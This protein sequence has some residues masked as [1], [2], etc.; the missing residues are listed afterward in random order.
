VNDYGKV[1]AMQEYFSDR[2]DDSDK[3]NPFLEPRPPASTAKLFTYLAAL[4]KGY[5]PFSKEYS[6]ESFKWPGDKKEL[7][8][9]QHRD[10]S[11]KINMFQA[12]AESQNIVT[13]R[14]AN[15]IGE[16]EVTRIAKSITGLSETL[17]ENKQRN[18]EMKTGEFPSIIGKGA[19]MIIGQGDTRITLI[20][21]LKAYATV[22]NNGIQVEPRFIQNI[23]N[24]NT[25]K[26]QLTKA[27]RGCN[28]KEDAIYD[29]DLWRQSQKFKAVIS[30]KSAKSMTQLLQG[31]IFDTKGT[32][33]LARF[34]QDKN[35]DANT[36]R[37]PFLPEEP[38][39]RNEAGK[40][41]TNGLNNDA[42]DLWFI[43][44]VPSE[45]MIAGVWLGGELDPKDSSKV[46]GTIKSATLF[47][48]KINGH[49]CAKIWREFMIEAIPSLKPL[50]TQQSSENILPDL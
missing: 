9:C 18:I 13:W 23:F 32:G 1:R 50:P 15:T 40:T 12:V 28:K 22:A 19:P 35:I 29:V 34:N 39:K 33:K 4:E 27:G 8:S 45:D 20:K 17:F 31:V 47:N 42:Q 7:G 5:S 21:M 41:G 24:S 38:E 14:I 16:K 10:K 48:E 44:Y 46:K 36:L 11:D 37:I 49:I 26:D 25:C 2:I 43:G 6:C 3:K 30:L